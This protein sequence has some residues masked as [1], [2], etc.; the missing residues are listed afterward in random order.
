[1]RSGTL[2][3]GLGNPLRSDDGVGPRVVVELDKRGLPDGVTAV[4]GGTGGLDLLRQL[5]KWQRVLVVD[6]A[7]IGKEPGQHLRFSPREARIST[8]GGGFSVHDAGLA[9]AIALAEALGRPLPDI[10]IFGLQPETLDWG[11]AL[12]PTVEAALPDL[13]DA[14][15]EEAIGDD[16]A[17][18]TRH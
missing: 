6:A 7:D 14:V 2:I 11:S 8:S 9:E 15:L 1:M 12:S 16:N 5:E 10:V 3:L 13:V 17:Q 18:D 4:D